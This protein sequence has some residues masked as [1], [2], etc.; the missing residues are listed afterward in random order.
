MHSARIGSV[1]LVAVS[2]LLVGCGPNTAATPTR[3]ATSTAPSP[4]PIPTPMQSPRT[5]MFKLHPCIDGCNPLGEDPSKYGQ[6]TVR[7]DIKND[8]YTI[9]VTVTGLTPDSR[10]LI[11]FHFGSCANVGLFPYDQITVATADATGKFTSATTRPGVYVVPGSGLVLTVHGDDRSRR[12]THL[13][14]ADMT[15]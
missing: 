10:H 8:A 7:V 4:S 14:C 1:A 6:G 2:L 5:L 3:A 12:E 9:T 13:A 11:N 15:N